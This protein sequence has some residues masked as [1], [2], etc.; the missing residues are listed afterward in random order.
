MLYLICD[1]MITMFKKSDK[2]LLIIILILF[3]A[4][5]VMVYSA[6]N[7]TAYMYN[8]VDPAR[9]FL[10]QI[11]FL[12]V[13]LVISGILIVF[14]T[15]TY[16]V[17]FRIGFYVACIMAVLV[18]IYGVAMN[19]SKSWIGYGGF[20]IQPSEFIKIFFIPFMATYYEANRKRSDNFLAM[21][22]P[23]VLVIAVIIIN[24]LQNDCGSMII[25]LLI[26][27]STFFISPASKQIKIKILIG[28][29]AVALL[30]V[31][32]IFTT[33]D[34]IVPKD[35]LERL[36]YQNPCERYLTTG[37]QLCNGYIA[38]N[39]GGLLGKGLGNSTQKYLYLPEGH[40]DFIFAIIIEELGL[41]GGI[42]LFLLYTYFLI[43]IVVIGKKST[44]LSH[45]MICYGIA[46]YF[47]FHIIVNVG[48]VTGIIP[49]TGIP[50]AFMSYGG[51]FLW[52]TLIG[53][54]IVQRIAYETNTKKVEEK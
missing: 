41:V 39:S 45:Q 49:L 25:F 7:V 30:G 4:G 26:A 21:C 24:Y 17:I 52:A 20:G 29:L 28:G 1:N 2:K 8:E 9:Y 32:L 43:R 34:K 40:T 14:P 15:K 6:S 37:N 23:L 38:I 36:F 35:K 47:F 46:F 51:S 53:I 31:L 48:G 10:R 12:I 5:L 3:L 33:G 54:T 42:G 19:G 50:L 18:I 27:A 11:A 13:G 22:A 44:K 16:K